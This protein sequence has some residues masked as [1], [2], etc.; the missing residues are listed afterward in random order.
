MIRP[1]RFDDLRP[2]RLRAFQLTGFVGLVT[3]E[4]APDVPAALTEVESA[5]DSGLWVAGFVAYEAA[6]GFDPALRVADTPSRL[7]AAWFAMY[8]G[9]ERAAPIQDISGGYELGEWLPSVAPERY[10]ADVD[11]VRDLIRHG[12]T[13]QTNY[14][15]RLD[16]PFA[17]EPAALYRD[18][19]LAQSGGYGALIDTG[20]HAIVSASPELFFEWEGDVLTTRP[21]KGTARRGR[22]ASEDDEQRRALLASEKDRAENLMI[23]DLLRNDMGRV[24]QF[25]TVHADR[26]F[27]VERFDTVWQLTSTI[28][29]FTRPDVGLGD[30]FAAL[31]PCGSVTGAPKVRTMEIIAELEAA[32]RGVYCG[33]VGFVG[34]PSAPGPRVAFNVAIRTVEVDRE[35]GRAMYGVGGG[36]TFDSTGT[37]EYEEALLKAEVLVRAQEPFELVETLRWDPIEGWWWLDRHLDRLRGSAA[38]FGFL[39]DQAAVRAELAAA[40]GAGAALRVRLVLDRRGR[41]RVTAEPAPAPAAPVRVA[42]DDVPVELSDPFLYHKTTR[43]ST[44]DSARQRHPDAEDVL[45]VNERGEVT[46]STVANVAALIDGRWVTPPVAA[47]CLPGVHR[48]VLID[49]GTLSVDAIPVARLDD[50]EQLALVNSVR[51]WMPAEAAINSPRRTPGLRR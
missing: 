22:W 3:A 13:Y 40:V 18:L 48:Q 28:R 23:V 2:G 15:M 36:V 49:E 32:R 29:S 47:G 4:R 50:C 33:A 43:R 12:E 46:E 5:A 17:G 6:P 14:T 16:A 26:L 44:Y 25:G 39:M 8:E 34:P 9:R 45:L 35:A 51:G 24:S 10:R 38:H 31:F 20:S 27:E 1:P 37:G 41:A 19:A 30:I 7:P 21:M 11:R 42:V